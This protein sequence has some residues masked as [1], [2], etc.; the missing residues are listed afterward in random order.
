MN[1]VNNE[2]GRATLLAK[3]LITVLICGATFAGLRKFG[4]TSTA[5]NFVANEAETVRVSVVTWGG[6]AGGQYFNRGFK[7]NAESE[8]YKKYGMKVEFVLQDDVAAGRE[9]FKADKVDAIWATADSFPTE[10]KGLS[11]FQPVIIMQSDWSHGGDAIVSRAGI[12]SINDLKGKKVAVA[13]GTPSHSFLL[14][15][16][17][18]SDM[19][20]KD[21][22]VV[23]KSNAVDAASD[24]KASAVDAAV[25]WSPDDQDCVAKV[26]GAKIL[27]NTREAN[28][29][30]ADVFFVKKSYLEKNRDKVK[31]LVE[32]W[33]TGNAQINSNP[34]ARAQAVKILAQGLNVDEG[35]AGTM[36][37]NARLTTFGDNRNFF[38]LTSGYNGVTGEKLY[39]N[40]TQEYSKIGMAPAGTPDW[41]RI[42]DS[43]VIASLNLTGSENDAEPETQF[44][45]PTAEMVSAPAFTTK[46]VSITFPTGSSTLDENAKAII[47]MSFVDIAKSFGNTRIRVEGNT[48]NTGSEP[49]NK[50]LSERRAQSVVEYL[51]TE[52]HFDRNRFVVVG[53]GSSKPVAG[54]S[55]GTAQGRAKNRRTDFELL[56]N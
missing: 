27:K 35:L 12:N 55:N 16:L 25:V 51:V 45:A 33:L 10:A 14:Y 1:I 2:S 50:A 48:D 7:A 20:I 53:N 11:E 23:E 15:A 21:I 6:Y 13:I 4:Q 9:A 49:N 28:R 56:G 39:V 38:G 5:Q 40:M 52:Q 47:A 24:F 30:I 34:S 46:K 8:Y 41:R 32:G 36:L 3:L 31:N 18:A 42:A 26:Q 43:S 54:V 19:T 37:G 22:T 17:K 44:T 29:I